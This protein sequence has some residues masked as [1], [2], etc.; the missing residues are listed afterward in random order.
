MANLGQPIAEVRTQEMA[1][2]GQQIAE[3]R[4]Q[5]VANLGQ[6]IAEVRTQEMH[7]ERIEQI[8]LGK[9]REALGL[10]KWSLWE[11]KYR[12]KNLNWIKLVCLFVC[13]FIKLDITI[14]LLLT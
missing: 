8:F 12:L 9:L 7:H 13:L 5:E 2:L 3:V 6:Q 11:T 4:T 10:G 1:N 14:E